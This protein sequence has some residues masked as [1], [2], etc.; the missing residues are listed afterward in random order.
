MYWNVKEYVDQGMN[1]EQFM[2]L[3]LFHMTYLVNNAMVPGKIETVNC[4]VDVTGVALRDFPVSDLFSMSE[5][6]KKHFT[7][8]M[9][10]LT[11]INV[12]WALRMAANVIFT[13]IPP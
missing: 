6:I 5:T 2:E 11:A 13:F 8:R 10:K 7:L 12:H 3:I 9:H 4:L 1:H